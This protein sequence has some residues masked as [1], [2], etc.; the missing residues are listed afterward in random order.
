MVSP[1]AIPAC[2]VAPRQELALLMDDQ[3]CLYLVQANV[4]T[5]RLRPALQL[6]H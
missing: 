3:R 6:E 5:Y 4:S 1:M 2:A